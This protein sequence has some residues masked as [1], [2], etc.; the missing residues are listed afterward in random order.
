VH[1]SGCLCM[2]ECAWVAGQDAHQASTGVGV[3]V[4]EPSFKKLQ[5]H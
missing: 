5:R 4:F 2:Y 3:F 1:E